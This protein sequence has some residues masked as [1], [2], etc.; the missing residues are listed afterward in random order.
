MS[1][2]CLLFATS[3]GPPTS[4]AFLAGFNPAVTLNKVGGPEG[5][6]YPNGSA[7][8]SSSKDLFKGVRIEKDWT[9]SF[10][11]SHAQL[12]KQLDQLRAEVESQLT[13][14]GCSISGR[15]QWSGDFS[16]FRFE[17]SSRGLRG[18]IRVTG[19]SFESGSQG[20]EILV[21]EH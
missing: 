4:S 19:V 16:G 1:A 9:F 11:G 15:G 2:V 8:T 6:T 20:L 18:F 14:S 21:Y 10:Q 12:S 13:S 5:I 3:C 17:Y 7:G